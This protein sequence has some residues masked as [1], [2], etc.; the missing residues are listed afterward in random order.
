LYDHYEIARLYNAIDINKDGQLDRFEIEK[1]FMPK[2]IN[3]NKDYRDIAKNLFDILDFDN[4]R[5]LD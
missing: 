3:Q 4:N 5:I 2:E 1:L